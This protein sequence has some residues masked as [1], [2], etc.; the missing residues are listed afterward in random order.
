MLTLGS[1]GASLLSHPKQQSCGAHQQ[2]GRAS[3]PNSH[4][5]HSASSTAQDVSPA[6]QLN[7][8]LEQLGSRAPQP[9]SH[10]EQLGSRVQGPRTQTAVSVP[11]LTQRAV[12]VHVAYMRALPARTVNLSGAGDALVAGMSS[13]LL[14]GMQPIVAL[15]HGMVSNRRWDLGLVA[16]APKQRGSRTPHVGLMCT[17]GR[18]F[19]RLL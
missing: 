8:H 17:T 18:F 6:P 9:S 7:S 3:Q 19:N 12:S 10:L 4:P 15:A 16:T 1:M 13:A 5:G 2:N 11:V 14:Q